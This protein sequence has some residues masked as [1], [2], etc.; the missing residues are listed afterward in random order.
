[1]NNRKSY[2]VCYWMPNEE[3]RQLKPNRLNHIQPST[4]RPDKYGA[5]GTVSLKDI[6]ECYEEYKKEGKED[7]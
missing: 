5:A 3:G 6:R 2:R 1:M 7:G 4:D